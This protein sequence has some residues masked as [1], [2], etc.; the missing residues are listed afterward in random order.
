[1][2]DY[3]GFKRVSHPFFHCPHQSS[4]MVSGQYPSTLSNIRLLGRITGA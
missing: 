1:L 4:P 2:L 3:P